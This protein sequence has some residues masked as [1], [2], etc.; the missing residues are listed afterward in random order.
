MTWPT[1]LQDL[2]AS[3]YSRRA[4][5]VDD[6]GSGGEEGWFESQGGRSL[7]Y[8]GSSEPHKLMEADCRRSS[9]QPILESELICSRE[10]RIDIRV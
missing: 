6:P 4:K 7:K 1:T 8:V 3:Q 9:Y 10:S 2:R 5:M